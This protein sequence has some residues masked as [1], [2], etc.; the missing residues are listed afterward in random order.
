MHVSSYYYNTVFSFFS[1]LCFLL[2]F[3]IFP[4]FSPPFFLGEYLFD[5]QEGRDSDGTTVVYEREEDLLA[6]QQEL[7]GVMPLH[8]GNIYIYYTHTHTHTL[9]HY[10]Y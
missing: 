4:S 6:L 7:L 10:Y 8:L 3:L 1:S 9:L 2:F 5:P